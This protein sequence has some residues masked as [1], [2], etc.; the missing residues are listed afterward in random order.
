[1]AIIR[2]K[3]TFSYN[4]YN[5][6]H[7]ISGLSML[8]RN[9]LILLKWP[10][11]KKPLC[12]ESGLGWAD[13]KIRCFG[14]VTSS[15]YFFACAPQSTKITGWSNL[16]MAE[17]TARVNPSHPILACERDCP[18]LT[19]RQVFNSKTPCSAHLVKSPFSTAHVPHSSLISFIMLDKLGG[20]LQLL[21]GLME[22]DMPTACPAFI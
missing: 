16:S 5:S 17:I 10:Q 3:N 4:L 14:F 12:A 18:S 15:R 13:V 2:N 1:M 9:S 20:N 6:H 19:V 21:C 11:P 7:T 8:D 22:N